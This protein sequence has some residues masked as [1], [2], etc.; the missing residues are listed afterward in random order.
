[1]IKEIQ[2]YLLMICLLKISQVYK[3]IKNIKLC[4]PGQKV[5]VY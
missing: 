2:K 4:L 5:D 1:M 3:S